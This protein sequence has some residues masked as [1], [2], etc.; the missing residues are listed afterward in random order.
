MT[1]TAGTNL[2]LQDRLAGAIWGH[3]VGDAVGVPYEFRPARPADQV[4]FGANGTHGQPPG[5]W[6]D[7]GAL[8]L[9]LLDSLLTKG[10]DTTDQAQLALAWYRDRAYTPDGDGRFD[11]GGATGEAIRAFEHG[12]PAEEAGLTHVRA[13]GN[14]SLM[15]I[16]PLALVERDIPDSELTD[17]AH[18]VSRV[19]H[20]TA[21][22]QVACALYCLIVRR[23]LAGSGGRAAALE[24]ARRSLREIYTASAS[25]AYLAALNHLEAYPDRGGRGRVC[26]SFW[27]AWDA[28]A[29]A[30]DYRQTVQRA[31]AYG[32]DTDTTAAIAGGLAGIR[33]GIGGIPSEWL[34][35]MRGREIVEPLVNRLTKELNP[36]RVA[37]I[38][39]RQVPAFAGLKGR[40]GM[41][42]LPGKQG[43]GVAGTHRR[44]LSADVRWL[45]QANA[46][47]TFLLLVEDHELRAL[48]VPQIAEAMAA[49]GIELVR[50]PI[51][52]AD[53]P[54]DRAA[55]RE[56]LKDLRSRVA[57]G[58]NVVVA[59]RGGLGRTGTVVACLLREAGLDGA[60]AVELTGAT[61]HGTIETSAQER[62][63]REWAS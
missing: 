57:V 58:Q 18:R 3:L 35:G 59:C 17:R 61:R 15:R 36:I 46:V 42:F 7:D 25:T 8:M 21:E 33:W 45:R 29:G 49:Q 63:V 43:F 13:S 62:F 2:D 40:V 39:N 20:G 41:T 56:T 55:F 48:G 12:T 4:E 31:V 30:N 52:D 5:T 47:D 34:R 37:W 54:S 16:L 23:V 14:G 53:I 11:V 9:A 26:D 60:A 10:F 24:D 27:S 19:T 32:N 44:E 1:T 51:V 50:H 28:F 38:D 6:S 22:A